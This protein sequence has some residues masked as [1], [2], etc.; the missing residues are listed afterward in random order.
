MGTGVPYMA[1]SAWS[2]SGAIG[3]K[4]SKTAVLPG[5]CKVERGGSGSRGTPPYY[6]GLTWPMRARRAGGATGNGLCWHDL[7]ER[8]LFGWG[9]ELLGASSLYI[10]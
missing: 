4:T 7:C 5:F 9:L 6:G 8:S 1:M 3:G 2:C 10:V